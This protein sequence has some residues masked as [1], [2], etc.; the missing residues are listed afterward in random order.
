LDRADPDAA[1]DAADPRDEAR[2]SERTLGNRTG[3]RDSR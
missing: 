3:R 1:V 2:V